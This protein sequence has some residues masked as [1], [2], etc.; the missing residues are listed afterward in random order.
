MNF[1]ISLGL[2]IL[3]GLANCG[4]IQKIL[5][6]ESEKD[7]EPRNQVPEEGFKSEEGLHEICNILPNFFRIDNLGLN[8][9]R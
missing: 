6:A 3:N 1:N 4:H 7:G 2:S 5:T 8:Y 9:A